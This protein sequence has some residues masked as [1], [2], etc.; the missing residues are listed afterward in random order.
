MATTTKHLPTFWSK[1]YLSGLRDIIEQTCR[2]ECKEAG[3]CVTVESVKY[4][5]TGG[6]ELGCV[7]GLIN[8]PR[9]P[10][11][12][13]TIAER[14]TK[15]AMKLLESTCQSS[16]LVMTPTQTTWITNRE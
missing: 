10:S 6:E 12:P 7:V 3:L 11:N 2:Q 1:I 13:E 5:Y 15:L 4:I 9:F 8:Y 14:A 16:V